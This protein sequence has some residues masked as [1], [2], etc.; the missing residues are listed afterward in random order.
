MYKKKTK[1]F[2]KPFYLYVNLDVKLGQLFKHI[3]NNKFTI[4]ILE[5]DNGKTLTLDENKV[6]MLALSFDYSISLREL[7]DKIG[8]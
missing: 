4:F 7:L 5:M 8:H 2:S 3:E 6:K 1:N